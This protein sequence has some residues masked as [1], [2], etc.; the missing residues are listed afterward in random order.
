MFSIW[1]RYKVKLELNSSEMRAQS[2][3]ISSME[4]STYSILE[5]ETIAWIEMEWNTVA[6]HW[7]RGKVM[8]CHNECDALIFIGV[9]V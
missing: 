1:M 2:L 7:N 9:I 4:Y 6:F 5:R 3:F 8:W